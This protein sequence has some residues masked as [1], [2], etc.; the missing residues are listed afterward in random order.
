MR[1]P[2]LYGLLAEFESEEALREAVRKAR[3]AGFRKIDAFTPYPIEG[4]AEDMGHGHSK[5]PAIVLIGAVLGA[6]TGAGLQYYSSVL[7]YP[8][9]IGGRPFNSWPSFVIVAFE[10][11]ILF[12]GLSAV[13][14]MLALNGLPQPHHPL[15][16]DPEF[17]RATGDGFF[18]CI[19]SADRH[20]DYEKTRRFLEELNPRHLADVHDL[21]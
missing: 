5:V 13:L 14:G 2:V 12:G 1:R 20:F 8:M 19:E 15:F 17:V 4:I 3:S 10:L 6:L 11:T 18:F 21:P 9:N 16:N 7:D